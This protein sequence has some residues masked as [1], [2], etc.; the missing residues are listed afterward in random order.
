MPAV[1]ETLYHYTTQVGLIGIINNSS[2]WATLIRYMNDAAEYQLGFDICGKSVQELAKLYQGKPETQMLDVMRTALWSKE[3]MNVCVTSFS[4][5]DDLLSQWR[6]Y[7]GGAAGFCLGFDTQMLRDAATANNPKFNL[8]ECIYEADAR[9]KAVDDLVRV[10]LRL[11]T[12]ESDDQVDQDDQ[13]EFVRFQSVFP[14]LA[15]RIKHEAFREEAEWRLISE[16]GVNSNRLQFRPGPSMLV[17]YASISLGANCEALTS[18][19]IGPTA[20]PKLAG[21]AVET[22]LMSKGI[23]H[24][25]VLRQSRAPYRAW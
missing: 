4:T 24:R 5:H 17:P 16:D 21:E 3:R 13:E 19:T 23:A 9:Q 20:H 25:V 11:K 10:F 2:I 8:A 22:L 7:A 18:I 6:G 14:R 15:A 12:Y 1:P